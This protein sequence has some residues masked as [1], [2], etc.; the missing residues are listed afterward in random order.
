MSRRFW[1]A[2]VI[3]ACVA[4]AP[5]P[6]GAYTIASGFTESCH[7]RIGFAAI[8]VLLDGLPLDKVVL[9][10]DGLWRDVAAQLEPAVLDSAGLAAVGTLTDAQKFVLFSAVVGIREP[11]TG[12]H[13]VS[14]LDDLRRAQVD[15]SP[16][17]QHLHCLRAPAED[18]FAG[19]TDVLR[20][21]EALIRAGL[22]DAA[23]AMAADEATSSVPLYLD[24]YG[25]LQVDVDTPSYLVGRAL[26]TVQD[27][28]AHT[29]R[30]ADAM[31]VFTVLNYIEGVEGTL[32]ES[33]DGM[34]HSNTMDDCRRPEL[35]PLVERA[36]AVSSALAA[37]AVALAA[38]GDGTL[39]DKGFAPCAAG[40]TQP[41][42]CAWMQY[43]AACAPDAQPPNV[44]G[45]CSQAN[46]YCGS[47]FLRVARESLTQPYVKEVLSCAVAPRARTSWRAVA[48]V[49]L[50]SLWVLAR[51]RIRRAVSTTLVVLAIVSPAGTARA[52][53]S[54]TYRS[55][56]FFAAAEGHFSLLS[57][58]P[59]RSFINATMGYGIRGGYRF[60]R[61][62]LVG[63]IER[64]YWLPT[65]L[66]HDLALG[67]LNIGAGAEWFVADGRVR[68]S[69][70]AGPSIL[71]FDATFDSKGTTG[72]FVDLRPA[73]LRWRASRYVAI[74]FDSLSVAIVAPVLG[75]PGILQLE[76]RTLLAVEA[77]P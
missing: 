35:A 47:P 12:G 61:W 68:L 21:S 28:Y 51:R 43:N 18:G 34:D 56:A 1:C 41:A 55:G 22:S 37:A 19:D 77:L 58:A 45:C 62:G 16:D 64:N 49:L 15:P 48:V 57:D 53:E 2:L 4:S 73:G 33:R 7:E 11:D 50:L 25:Q 66:S 14:N 29:L 27:C 17:S 72:V 32:V 71:W 60:G 70:T 8:A 65:E 67:A 46:G 42:T 10:A 52:D 3:V 20:G 9:P 26:H 44:A 24:F 30:S 36:A 69:A 74:A 63:Q 54:A 59:E 13:S 31:T 76:Y 39:I 75:A 5:R 38:N 40:E 6:A 23:A